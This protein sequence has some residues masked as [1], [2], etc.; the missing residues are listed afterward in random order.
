[1][2]CGTTTDS[3]S[4]GNVPDP[5]HRP[6]C[7]NGMAQKVCDLKYHT[8]IVIGGLAMKEY[9]VAML[10][11]CVLALVS[12]LTMAEMISSSFAAW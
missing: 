4:L 1:M 7:T 10:A 11:G 3:V 8:T 6:A 5:E 2:H 12:T 9:L